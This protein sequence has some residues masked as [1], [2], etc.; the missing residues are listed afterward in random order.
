MIAE[1]AQEARR[2]GPVLLDLDEEFEEDRITS[3]NVCY[4]KL[5]RERREGTFC[6][7]VLALKLGDRPTGQ[8]LDFQS[9]YHL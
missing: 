3:Y 8:A 2:I 9:P 6:E 1:F 7:S 4:T 5:L